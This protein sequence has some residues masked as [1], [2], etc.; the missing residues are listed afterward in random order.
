MLPVAECRDTVSVL[1]EAFD[2]VIQQKL[3]C[4]CI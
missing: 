2:D 3:V 1:I 4:K